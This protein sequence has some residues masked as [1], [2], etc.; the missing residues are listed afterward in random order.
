MCMY[1]CMYVCM[2]IGKTHQK[3]NGKACSCF[4]VLLLYWRV[5]G[6]AT[7]TTMET[8]RR[9]GLTVT[10]LDSGSTPGFVDRQEESSLQVFGDMCWSLSAYH[11]SF[12]CWNHFAWCWLLSIRE[13][14]WSP[15]TCPC[16]TLVCRSLI[17]YS[18]PISNDDT[19]WYRKIQQKYLFSCRSRRKTIDS[20]R[21]TI[22]ADLLIRWNS[23]LSSVNK[24]CGMENPGP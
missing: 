2:Y 19:G 24:P 20:V 1:V 12:S 7:T 11:M 16:G 21:N 23:G 9:L 10:T 13:K 14:G 3:Q 8:L 22:T 15:L 17:A 5:L 4:V 6:F 18:I